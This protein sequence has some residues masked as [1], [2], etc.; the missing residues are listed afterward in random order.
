[1]RWLG[2]LF[3]FSIS[4]QPDPVESWSG[5]DLQ[6]HRGCRGLQ[7]ENSIPAMM[8]ALELGVN[9]LEMD[10]V[11]TADKQIILSHEPFMSAQICLGEGNH[12]IHPEEQYDLNIY[13]MTL[14]EVQTFDCG[15]KPH[16][17][18]PEQERTKV[19]KPLLSDVIRAANKEARTLR[20]TLPLFNIEMKMS[21]HG[22]GRFHPAPEEFASLLLD[23]IREEEIGDRCTVQSFDMRALEA[24]HRQAPRMRTVVL[25]EASNDPI[26]RVESL[27]FAPYALSP[28]HQL[29]NPELL[30]WTT[31]K[32]LKLI[33]W[34]VNDTG[35][36]KELIEMGVDGLITDYPD[37]ML[38]L[39]P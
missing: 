4:C 35:R 27:S 36:A 8:K 11:I 16:P 21:P 26:K 1:M 34:T 18:F 39:I 37:R 22:D 10:V 33:P 20:R 24:L 13:R 38:A 3:L 23:V 19:V 31:T 30:E 9:T 25:V 12:P 7:P 15:S 32:G 29:V 6:G 2:L 5:F 17:N 14:D 28:E